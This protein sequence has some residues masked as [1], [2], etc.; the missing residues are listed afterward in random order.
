[1][2]FRGPLVH[3]NWE[4]N[5]SSRVALVA[6]GGGITPCFQLI[7]GILKH[8]E[9]KTHITL[10]FGNQTNE[11]MLLRNEL[12]RSRSAIPG[13]FGWFIRSRKVEREKDIG[14]THHEGATE[15]RPAKRGHREACKCACLRSPGSGRVSGWE[16]GFPGFPGFGSTDGILGDG[17]TTAW[18][19]YVDVTETS[20]QT[21]LV[22]QPCLRRGL[23]RITSS[24]IS[25][26]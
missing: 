16:K 2:S 24:T 7:S 10:V 3:Y 21:R 18:Y 6:G 26:G 9:G 5:A 25:V 19:I 14:R 23:Q 13:R 20:V 1:M 4:L 11:D 8:P 17:T 22:G 12:D 15:E